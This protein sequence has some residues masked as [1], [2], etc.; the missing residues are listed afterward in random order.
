[1]TPT[2]EAVVLPIL[3]LTVLLLG[4]LRLGGQ[5][6]LV[7]PSPYMLILGVL[8]LRVVV[9]SAALAPGRLLASRRS[10]LANVNGGVVLATLCV[11]AAQTM[12]MLTPESG[13]PRLALN[14]F[15]L[16]LLLNT[17]AAMPD[18]RRLLRS[19]GVIFGSAFILKF[20]VLSEL[21]APGVNAPKRALQALL[22]A[23]TLGALVQ[24]P[25]HPAAGYIAL[26]AALLFLIGVWLLPHG[27]TR[28][29]EG[30]V[31]SESAVPRR[32]DGRRSPRS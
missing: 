6:M 13:V 31:R 8:F 5:L 29:D 27:D 4:G 23:V 28:L 25:L 19:L 15:F 21:S 3:F 20:V 10:A 12:M 9:Q 17:A 24:S 1:M 26:L 2:R 14:V 11:A 18:R 22:D 7:P 16:I 32:G 30:L